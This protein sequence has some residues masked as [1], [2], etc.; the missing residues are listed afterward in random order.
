MPGALIR[1]K[2]QAFHADASVGEKTRCG[3]AY[4][5]AVGIAWVRFRW[6]AVFGRVSQGR[7]LQVRL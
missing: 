3:S 5:R 1:R 4:T 2:L 6:P 7:Y